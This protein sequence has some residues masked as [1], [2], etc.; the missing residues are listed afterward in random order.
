M[1]PERSKNL[2]DALHKR[3]VGLAVVLENVEDPHNVSAIMRT[4][5]AVGI[6]DIYVICT[7]VPFRKKWGVRSSRSADKWITTHQFESVEECFVV[8]RSKFAKIL[9][10]DV[11]ADAVGL[12][13]VDFTGS[14]ALV[15]G[16]EQ[17]GVSD[18]VKQ[19]CDGKFVIPQVGIIKSLNISVACAVTVYEAYRQRS[20]AGSYNNPTLP[21]EKM[22]NLFT[23]WSFKRRST[24]N[25]L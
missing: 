2:L 4:C 16:N 15:F 8:L 22:E 14:I 1:S 9:T 17:N 13:D 24:I 3:Q 7:K 21:T 23:E 19:L 11:S 6:Q 5:D 12:Y 20:L 25:D 10:T 18:E